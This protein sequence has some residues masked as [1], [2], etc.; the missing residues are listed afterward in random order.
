MTMSA[1]MP[2]PPSLP[3]ETWRD[4]A[5]CLEI[6]GDVFFPEK[7]EWG[8]VRAAKAICGQCPVTGEC[9]SFAFRIGADF[10]IFG[11]L[12]AQERRRLLRDKRSAA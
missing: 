2:D 5:A 6:G 7:G 9:L 10:G 1:I 12:T 4:F 11:G 8:L 3:D